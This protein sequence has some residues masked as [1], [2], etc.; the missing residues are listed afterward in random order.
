MI[1]IK[2]TVPY[3][4]KSPTPLTFDPRVGEEFNYIYKS[5]DGIKYA[6]KARLE[7]GE[8]PAGVI[9]NGL[10]YYKLANN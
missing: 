1:D 6:L 3:S 7:N 4:S 8:D 9:E 5:D 10:I 2:R